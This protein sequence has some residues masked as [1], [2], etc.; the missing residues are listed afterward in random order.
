MLTMGMTG[1]VIT[2]W[3]GDGRITM[4]EVQFRVQVWPGDTLTATATVTNVYNE[5]GQDYADFDIVTLNQK[6][7]TV[8]IG[9]ATAKIDA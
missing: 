8:L 6:D 7:E 3:V 4:Y 1:R 9:K 2:D 5:G